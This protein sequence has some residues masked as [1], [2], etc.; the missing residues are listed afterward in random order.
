MKKRIFTLCTCILVLG[1]LIGAYFLVNN[2]GEGE[3]KGSTAAPVLSYS[4][5]AIDRATL[6][7][8]GFTY[9]GNTFDFTIK[10]DYSGWNL[11]ANETLPISNT[12]IAQMVTFFEN[13]TSDFRIEDPTAEKLTEYG[14]DDP[15][16]EI[17]FYDGTGRHGFTVG[18]FNSFNSTYY[19]KSTDDNSNVYLVSGE[20]MDAFSLKEADL[21]QIEELPTASLSKKITLT[22]ES[23]DDILVYSYYPGGKSGY[24]NDVNTWF[25]SVNGKNE[26]PIN[27]ELAK[28][29]SDACSYLGFAQ[30]VSYAESDIPTYGLDNAVTVTVDYTHV[31]IEVDSETGEQTSTETAESRTFLLGN[32]D[33]DGYS[34]AKTENSPLIYVTVSNVYKE[35]YSFDKNNLS[36]ICSGY[37]FNVLNDDVTEIIFNRDGK[38]HVLASV[39]DA[40]GI[41]YTV[42][43]NEIDKES[44]LELISAVSKISWD[45]DKTK[46][47]AT[48]AENSILK[49]TLKSGQNSSNVDFTAFSDDFYGATVDYTDVLLVSDEKVDKI[50]DLLDA[51]IK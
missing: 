31:E 30:C 32:A 50:I 6:Y 46:E 18:M 23:G 8:L 49:I 39:E 2:L 47:T 40:A 1:A 37:V 25:L 38:E 34:Y 12:V 29:L 42:D 27:E 16:A 5:A 21:I 26:F 7:A 48:S 51:L 20:F 3:D 33:E 44:A 9:D 35:L 36:S 45:T 10:E 4:V 13:M 15:T 43:G 11:K 28:N 17:Y 14:F 24:I 41:E 19:V 22:I